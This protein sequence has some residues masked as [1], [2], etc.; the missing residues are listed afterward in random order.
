V[1]PIRL[2]TLMSGLF[3]VR[4]S[5]T[6]TDITGLWGGWATGIAAAVGGG[7]LLLDREG[8]SVFGGIAA[9]GCAIV[10]LRNLLQY[11]D[12]VRDYLVGTGVDINAAIG[13]YMTLGGAIGLGIAVL[14]LKQQR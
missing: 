5:L 3:D 4:A 11:R 14:V 13:L 7:A 12:V 1:G 10:A 6:G 8:G 9:V 2:D